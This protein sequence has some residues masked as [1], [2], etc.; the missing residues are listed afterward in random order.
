VERA[1][2][3][4]SLLEIGNN[5]HIDG[6]WDFRRNARNHLECDF[7]VVEEASMLDTGLLA[8]LLAACRPG[9]HILFVGDPHQ[10]PP[11]GHGAPLRDMIAAGM[12]CGALDEIIR[13]EG[14]I[15]AACARIKDG[16]SFETARYDQVEKNLVHIVASSSTE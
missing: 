3:I 11:V 16:L 2:T 1:T 6:N 8:C 5:G 7:L 15:V 9:C 10:L 12:A 13:N 14:M 4:H